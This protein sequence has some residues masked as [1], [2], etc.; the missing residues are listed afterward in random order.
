MNLSPRYIGAYFKQSRL[1]VVLTWVVELLLVIL[2][3]AGAAYFFGKNIVIQEGSM[4]PTLR[5]GDHAMMNTLI[6][7]VSSPK[8]GDIVVFRSED[9]EKSSLSIKRIIGLPGETIQIKNGKIIINGKTHIEKSDFPAISDAGLAE[10]KIVLPK[11]EYFVMG[12]NRNSSEDSRYAEIG[13]IKKRNILGKLW[14]LSAPAGRFGLI[15]R[16]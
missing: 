5:A 10:D 4:E 2:L 12:D 14:L 6:Y 15:S 16:V 11:G 1:R 3:A 8:R 13:N 7:K 9:E